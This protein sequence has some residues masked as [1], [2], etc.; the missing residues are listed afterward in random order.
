MSNFQKDAIY[1]LK[2]TDGAIH[3]GMMY[4][5]NPKRNV[6]HFMKYMRK[7]VNGKPCLEP[8]VFQFHRHEIETW[9]M[10]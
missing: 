1:T 10:I 8:I 6:F 3:R 9:Q 5:G 4:Y 2:A 7:T